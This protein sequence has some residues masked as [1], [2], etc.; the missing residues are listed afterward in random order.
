MQPARTPPP[1]C[2]PSPPPHPSRTSVHAANDDEDDDGK[3]H[4]R[5]AKKAKKAKKMRKHGGGGGVDFG[6]D[7]ERVGGERGGE[8]RLL[9]ADDGVGRAEMPRPHASAG[10]SAKVR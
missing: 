1:T 4:R 3:M 10:N 6:G 2:V 5:K 8:G 7:Y 9:L